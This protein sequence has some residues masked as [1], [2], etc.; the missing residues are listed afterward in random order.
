MKKFFKVKPALWLSLLALT[1]VI[2]VGGTMAVLWASDAALTNQFE[3]AQVDTEIKEEVGTAGQKD[4]SIKNVGK[5][6]AYIRARIMVSGVKE[7]QVEIVAE[8]PTGID[9]KPD[10][11][12][13][14]MPLNKWEKIPADPEQPQEDDFYYYKEVVYGGAADATPANKIP[15]KTSSLLTKVVFGE[16]LKKDNEF[17][18]GFNITVY[19][20]SVLATDYNL[21]NA[22]A[23]KGVFDQATMPK[24]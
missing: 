10:K 16:N 17:L 6:P 15:T 3:L 20:E 4:V 2:L 23:I 7:D 24:Q 1:A 21:T 14:V 12:Y 11:V 22:T 8:E 18:S 19:H 9:V 5:S 13:L